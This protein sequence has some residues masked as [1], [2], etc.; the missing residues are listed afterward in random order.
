M[1]VKITSHNVDA[2]KKEKLNQY[3]QQ[4]VKNYNAFFQTEGLADFL[5]RFKNKCNVRIKAVGLG[6][7]EIRVECPTLESLENLKSDYCS[8]YLDEM[9]EKCML[10]DDVRQKLNLK[11]VSLKV[12]I[13]QEDYDRCRKSFLGPVRP[14]SEVTN[15]GTGLKC[16]LQLENLKVHRDNCNNI[17]TLNLSLPT[18]STQKTNIEHLYYITHFYRR[19]R[20]KIVIIEREKKLK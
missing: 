14:S 8:G 7:L 3:F 10:T 20:K 4:E 5:G 17:S 18:L 1:S 15:P 13:R 11:D 16:F 2:V 6:S 19:Q 12:V 9:A